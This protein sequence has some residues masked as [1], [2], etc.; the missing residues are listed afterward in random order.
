VD[1]NSQ[2]LAQILHQKK[3][4]RADYHAGSD[5]FAHP[6]TKIV[7]STKVQ[8]CILRFSIC[9]DRGGKSESST[10]AEPICTLP[11]DS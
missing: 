3:M 10:V 9:S 8:A 2:N 7:H 11:L 1:F 6:M 5:N 4:R